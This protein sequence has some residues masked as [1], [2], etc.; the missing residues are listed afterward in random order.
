VPF[1][2]GSFTQTGSDSTNPFQTIQREEVGTI[3]KITPQISEG[4][5][6]ILKIE[7][8]ASDIASSSAGAVDLIT[9]KR[10]ITTNVLVEDGGIIV[11]GGLMRDELLDN[12]QRVPFLGSI[13]IIG[14][15]FKVRHSQKV[16]TNLMVFIR[17]KILRDG[18]QTA[19][20]TNSKY[21]YMRDRQLEMHDGKAPLL[22][23]EKVPS[24]PQLAPA[25]AS[26]ASDAPP[27]PIIDATKGAQTRPLPGSA[28]PPAAVETPATS[29]PDE[30]PPA[31]TVPPPQ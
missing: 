17:P 29:P 23:F 12:E 15:L 5:T 7:Q 8:E 26:P 2:T 6:V 24:L 9:N 25:S 14:Q 22:P 1:I 21:N 31:E 10:T 16:K 4:D 20:E 11:L 3:L 30:K 13:P 27:T 19:Y 28:P 18:A